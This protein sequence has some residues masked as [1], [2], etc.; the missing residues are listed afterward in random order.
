MKYE[1]S[2]LTYFEALESKNGL[3]D[4]V[5]ST[6]NVSLLHCTRGVRL[7][8]RVSFHLCKGFPNSRY[9]HRQFLQVGETFLRHSHRVTPRIKGTLSWLINDSDDLPVVTLLFN[10]SQSG[11]AVF[12]LF[13]GLFVRTVDPCIFVV[14]SNTLHQFLHIDYNFF[15]YVFQVVFENMVGVLKYFFLN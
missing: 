13:Q 14:I 12:E 5:E 10:F 3:V 4:Y 15:R 6:L 11:I 1:K 8:H 2:P 9:D 7:V